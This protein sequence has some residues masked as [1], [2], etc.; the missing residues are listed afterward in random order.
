MFESSES[1]FVDG[2]VTEEGRFHVREQ[3]KQYDK[4]TTEGHYMPLFRRVEK[5]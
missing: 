2:T 5:I 3:Q 4:A 1:N